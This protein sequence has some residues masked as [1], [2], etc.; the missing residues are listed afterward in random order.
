MQEHFPA[1]LLPAAHGLQRMYWRIFQPTTHGVKVLVVHPDDSERIMLVRNSYGDR[2][3]FTLPGGGVKRHETA[4]VAGRREVY[5][6][7]GIMLGSMQ[8]LVADRV[9]TYEGKKDYVTTLAATALSGALALSS[10][11][12][13]ARWVQIKDAANSQPLSSYVQQ[14]IAAYER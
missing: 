14:A 1:F 3:R 5:E 7:L 4:E 13:D 11:I 8:V 9:S 12:R 2:E 10:E 6:E